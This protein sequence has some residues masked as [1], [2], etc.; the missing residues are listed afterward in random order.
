MNAFTP[1]TDAELVRARNDPEF[2]QKLL[3]NN[4][5]A[6]LGTLQ[7][8]RQAPATGVVDL[9]QMREGVVLAVRLAELIQIAA[10]ARNH[11]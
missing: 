1:V 8:H 2:R 6:L 3:T 9:Q 11:G 5:E 10:G 7:R 4:L